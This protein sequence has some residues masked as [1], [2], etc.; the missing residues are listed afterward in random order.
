MPEFRRLGFLFP[1]AVL[2]LTAS[3]ANRPQPI[4]DYCQ[5]LGRTLSEKERVSRVLLF[6]Y[7]DAE[8]RHLIHFV[9]FRDQHLQSEPQDEPR[10]VVAAYMQQYPNCC[11]AVPPWPIRQYGEKADLFGR[12]R[13][14]ERVFSDYARDFHWTHDVLIS[15]NGHLDQSNRVSYF[16]F[17]Q[18]DCGEVA[19]ASSHG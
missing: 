7:P 4:R 14:A 10:D 11:A 5:E 16:E 15:V 6:A 8:R 19:R 13:T 18:S 3:C 2:A 1:A 17:E 12:N 9:R